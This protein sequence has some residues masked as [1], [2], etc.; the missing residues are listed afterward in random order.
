MNDFEKIRFFSFRMKEVLPEVSAYLVGGAVIDVIQGREIKDWD[1]EVFGASLG[2]ISFF[3]KKE[4]LPVSL[5]GESF[6]VLK[7]V[8]EGLDIDI[9]VP[10]K[11]NKIGRGHRCFTAEFPS[12]ISMKEA[13]R[14]RDLTINSMSID[15]SDGVLVDNYGGLEDLKKGWLRATD[16]ETFVEDPL[17]VL[18][19]MQL[20]PRKGKVVVPQTI[21]LCKKMKSEF[22]DLPKERIFEEFSKLL[23]KAEKPSLGLDFLVA[24][25]WIEFFPELEELMGCQQNPEWHPEGDVWEHTL[26]TIDIAASVR[27]MI[28]ED[29]RLAFMFGVLLHDVGKPET[30]DDALHA[31]GHDKA[32]V[33]IA[34]DFMERITNDK[35]LISR[36]ISIVENHMRPGQ[37]CHA[38]KVRDGAWK[39]LHNKIR[40]DVIAYVCF[41]DYA[42]TKKMVFLDMTERH[43]PS[44]KALEWFDILGEKKVEPVLLGRHLIALGMTPSRSFGKILKK[45]Y[46]YQIDLGL[47][48]HEE[49]IE[50]LRKNDVLSS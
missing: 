38:E 2:A 49:I 14:R 16:D 47:E 46:E 32:G 23:L 50:E 6:G 45:A 12:N 36:V 37:L 40:L 25:E 31:Y 11:E 13:A 19:I 15:L 8:Y 35:T 20:L 30:T 7:T 17:R 34:T 4:K 39:R 10:R 29:W 1:I 41:S 48:S 33:P 5:V 18:R 26:A 42:S 24:C 28:P 27:E 3:L 21:E 44:Y 9:S 43:E 22:S